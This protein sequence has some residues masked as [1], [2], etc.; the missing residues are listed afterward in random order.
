VIGLG[1]GIAEREIC[2]RRL[3]KDTIVICENQRYHQWFTTP[4][5]PDGRH[6]III[7]TMDRKAIDYAVVKV[8]KNTSLAGQI[9]VVDDDSSL[10]QYSGQ[11]SWH[12]ND[13]FSFSDPDIPTYYPYGNCT[14][15]SSNPGDNFTF[16]FSGKQ[17][18]NSLNRTIP[19]LSFF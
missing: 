13:S 8:G 16:R 2:K 19:N 5:L 1:R 15:R 17:G 4:T 14:H 10:I 9:V 6:S 7:S 12:T 11:W 3:C 18:V